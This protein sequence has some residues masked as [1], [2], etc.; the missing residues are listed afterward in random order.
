MSVALM[1][2]GI[3]P[4]HDLSSID[5]EDHPYAVSV[6]DFT[7]Q[8]DLLVEC[9]VGLYSSGSIP[10]VVITFDDGHASN[11]QLAAPLLL[12][13]NLPAYF[14]VTSDFIE[15]RK[16]FLSGAELFELSQ[17]PGLCIGSHGKTHRFFN[18]MSSE[19]SEKELV[20]SRQT[21]ER[22]CGSA[23][24]SISF[25][26]GRFSLQTLNQLSSAGYTQWFGSE[27]DVIGP[28]RLRHDPPSVNGLS[29]LHDAQSTD[30][31]FPDRW[32]LLSQRG[33]QPLGRV[34]IRNN[35]QLVEFRRIIGQEPA[36]FRRK[37]LNSQVKRFARRVIGNR[38]YHGL[39]KSI[40]ER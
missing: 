31:L 26:G 3:F 18:D 13:R 23:C 39:Y 37:R 15:R 5:A 17:L 22:L 30:D 11:L 16:H 32:S 28:E 24:R 33:A 40:A 2:H 10:D 12:E 38:L 7:R 36:Y 25:P 14:F 8:L 21:L 34:A 35:T 9:K 29:T 27:V 4:D 6:S 20:K 1:Y 19:D